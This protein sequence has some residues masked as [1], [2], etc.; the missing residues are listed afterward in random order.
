MFFP[1]LPIHIFHSA[2][3]F[4]R[5]CEVTDIYLTLGNDFVALSFSVSF[6]LLNKCKYIQLKCKQISEKEKT[7][8]QKQ[9]FTNIVM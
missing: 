3:T 9:C 4:L 5:A 7:T 2:N 1:R 6:S 8:S